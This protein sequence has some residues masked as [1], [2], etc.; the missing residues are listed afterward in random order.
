MTLKERVDI[1]IINGS[2]KKRIASGSGTQIQDINKLLKQ[3]KQMQKR[4]WGKLKAVL[5]KE[6]MKSWSTHKKNSKK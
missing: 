2:R 4:L 1:T 6:N 5:G 3:F